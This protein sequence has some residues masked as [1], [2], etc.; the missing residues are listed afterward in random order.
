MI[1]KTLYINIAGFVNGRLTESEL[2]R[3][4]VEPEDWALVGD[5]S[6]NRSNIEFLRPTAD[7]LSGNEATHLVAYNNKTTPDRLFE[8]ELTQ[9]MI[10]RKGDLA[11]FKAKAIVL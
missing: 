5:N 7:I 10:V 2:P 6:F 8:Q 3:V 1:N 11:E 4:A 9:P